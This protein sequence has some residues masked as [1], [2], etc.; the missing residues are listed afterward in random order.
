MMLFVVCMVAVS[1]YLQSTP[2]PSHPIPSHPIP[3]LEVTAAVATAARIMGVA[4][5]TGLTVSSLIQNASEKKVSACLHADTAVAGDDSARMKPFR[6]PRR[7]ID[8]I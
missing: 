8:K 1:L 4:A 7:H 5:S 2:F 6:C 3:F